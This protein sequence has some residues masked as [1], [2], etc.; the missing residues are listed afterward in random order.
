MCLV[1]VICFGLS[2][3][4]SVWV[5]AGWLM[6]VPSRQVDGGAGALMFVVVHEVL[7]L[8][9]VL[10]IGRIRGWSPKTFG[11]RVSLKLTGA[12][13]LLALC[14]ALVAG[15]VAAMLG[16]LNPGGWRVP[17]HGQITLLTV[18]VVSL[19]NPLF[20]EFTELGY[21]VYSLQRFGICVAIGASAIL[22]GFLHAYG[23][24]N[25]VLL[26]GTIG[27]VFVLAYCR[28]RQL[29][30]PIVAHAMINF[31]SLLPLIHSH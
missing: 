29:W 24:L 25:A 10:W 5:V 8:A 7:A 3:A 17:A 31:L 14:V 2:I 30:P 9:V 23:G 26:N 22:R 15:L 28:W 19:I 20:E 6:S 13:V 11:L 18:I 16:F 27:L 21:L 12:G 1:F 4:H